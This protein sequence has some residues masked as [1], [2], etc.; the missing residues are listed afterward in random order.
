MKKQLYIRLISLVALLSATLPVSANRIITKT[1][2]YEFYDEPYDWDGVGF[3][4]QDPLT[5]E[6]N[7]NWR[8]NN[9]EYYGD[10]TLKGEGNSTENIYLETITSLPGRVTKVTIEAKAWTTEGWVW[11]NVNNGDDEE[12]Q[13]TDQ[14][15]MDAISYEDYVFN[16]PTDNGGYLKI[17]FSL[18]T[19]ARIYIRSITVEYEYEVPNEPYAL[20]SNDNKTLTFYYDDQKDLNDYLSVGPF[21]DPGDQSW[22][23]HKESIT[24]V[25]FAN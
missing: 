3:Y 24:T 5:E 8:G 17:S 21:D 2:V 15:D 13:T 25:N 7:T 23:D 1:E 18:S 4:S 19:Y 10:K 9:F 14:Y 20:L 12:I 22:K 16:N 6:E 11:M